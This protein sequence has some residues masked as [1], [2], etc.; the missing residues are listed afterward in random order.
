[1][2]PFW[3]PVQLWFK[4]KAWP[5]LRKN[6]LWL[7]SGVGVVVV[8]YRAFRRSPA[9]VVAPEA[10][11][12]AKVQREAMELVQEQK[13]EA[14]AEFEGAVG[15]LEAEHKKELTKADEENQ[16]EAEKLEDDPKALNDFLKDVGGS[17]HD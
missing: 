1:M 7:L 15:E 16:A 13:R 12:A 14:E 17:V 11:G 9:P 2:V 4:H 10:L 3:V 5:W 8:L 6:W